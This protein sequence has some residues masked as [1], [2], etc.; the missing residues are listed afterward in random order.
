[1]IHGK[2]KKIDLLSLKSP[3]MRTFHITWLAFFLCFFGWFGISPMLKVVREDLGIT[4]DQIVTANMLAVASTVF[5]RLIIGWLCDKIGPRLAYA[6]LLI[7]GSV[8]VMLIGL[9]QNFEQ[10]LLFRFLIG[11]IGAS[12]VITQFHT[13]VMFAPNVVGT[14]NA[15]TAGWGNMGGGVT[16]VIMPFVFA[17]ML[18]LFGSESLAWR[19]AMVGPGIL[20]LIMGFVYLKFTQD[21]PEGNYDQVKQPQSPKQDKV[22]LLETVKD[23]RV[24]IL[25]LIYGSC[26][27]VELIVNSK[28]ALYFYDYFNMDIKTAGMIAGLFGLMNLFARSTGG[29]LGDKFGAKAGLSGRVKWMFVALVMEGIALVI[30]S[31]MGT[32]PTII[33]SLLVFSLF[34]QMSEGA[35]FS[36]VPFINNKALGLVSGIVGAGGNAGAVAGMFLFKKQLTGLEWT[37]SFFYLG[38]IVIC[39]SFLSFFIR[40]SSKT[41]SDLKQEMKTYLVEKEKSAEKELVPEPI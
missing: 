10:F 23:H 39:I 18:V 8:P 1:M 19:Y 22:N 20:L 25:F 17:G 26:F 27:G 34:V 33:A 32:I 24:W 6:W 12:F 37:D 31:R 41:E 30:F 28:A 15:T 3:H 16:Q 40:F 13:S 21:T 36:V 9:S 35:T 14:A 11:A 2:A 4:T 7:I 29:W 38:L 5:M